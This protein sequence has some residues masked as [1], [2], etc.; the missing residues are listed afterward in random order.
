MRTDAH[1]NIV[2]GATLRALELY[3][4]ALDGFLAWSGDSRTDALLAVEEA[5]G[6]TMGH[7][8]VALLHMVG[9]DPTWL[10]VARASLARLREL[11]QTERERSYAAA[12]ATGLTGD[13]EGIRSLIG[14]IAKRYPRDL[15][16]LAMAHTLDYLLGDTRAQRDRVAAALPAWS[17]ADHGYHGVLAMHAFGLEETGEYD[18]AEETAFAVLDLAPANLRAHHARAHVLEMQGR[19]AEGV[20]WMEERLAHWDRPGASGTH[21]WWHLSLYH[22]DLGDAKR[23]LEIY[24][25]RLADEGAG[26]S[27]LIDA[28]ALLWR[29]KLR[30]TTLGERWTRL[31]DRWAPRAEHAFCAFSDVH[32]MLA[33][34]GAGRRDLQQRLLRTQRRRLALGGTN[35]EMIRN[36]GLPAA[37]ALAA[38][39]RGDYARAAERLRWLPDVSHRLGGSH[40]QRGILGLTLREALKRRPRT[41]LPQLGFLQRASWQTSSGVHTLQPVSA[42]SAA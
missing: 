40:A 26:V 5:P 32:A 29:L 8:M 28:S 35:E 12:I 6:F 33:F 38:F 14:G 39:G 2:T 37:E 19:T 10:P 42:S 15:L 9:R 25:A 16:A 17:R 36:V 30:G 34:V 13:F 23:A 31:A 4:R 41:L 7:A 24:D 11:P 21:V 22:L 20:R 18:R 3:E 1:G 27:E